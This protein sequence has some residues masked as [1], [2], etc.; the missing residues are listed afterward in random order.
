MLVTHGTY[1]LSFRLSPWACTSESPRLLSLPLG[2]SDTLVT[3]CC[4]PVKRL[5][6]CFPLSCFG[7]SLRQPL[8]PLI[9]RVGLSQ[10]PYPSS[11]VPVQYK[12][13]PLTHRQR[14]FLFLVPC[15][16]HSESSHVSYG[17]QFLLLFPKLLNAFAPKEKKF[18]SWLHAF[19]TAVF[20]LLP[21]A[22]PPGRL[23][24]P[25]ASFASTLRGLRRRA[26]KLLWAFLV[27]LVT[28]VLWPPIGLLLSFR[29]SQIF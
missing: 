11:Q 17:G 27:S 12:C 22:A 9:L 15:S 26:C 1:P 16:S 6:C 23:P 7:L 10:W 19:F 4:E 14:G 18:Q 25:S 5:E 13:L 28:R 2:T 29:N 24:P 21:Q 3:P 8:C 20:A